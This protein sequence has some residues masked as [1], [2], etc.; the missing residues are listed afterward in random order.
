MLDQRTMIIGGAIL[1]A[2]VLYYWYTHRSTMNKMATTTAKTA[3]KYT[4]MA[5]SAVN[6]VA[7][8]MT[9]AVT[10]VS[11]NHLTVPQSKEYDVPQTNLVKSLQDRITARPITPITT[12]PRKNQSLDLRQDPV[13]D[14][15]RAQVLAA[16][17]S[18][19][20]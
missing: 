9:P 17:M 15:S 12:A 5:A 7:D 11:G 19:I 13:V 6:K 10:K 8:K 2:I 14:F 1:A 3:E 18:T 16:P 20:S 4:Q